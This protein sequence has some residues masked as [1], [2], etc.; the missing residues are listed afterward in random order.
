MRQL[1]NGKLTECIDNDAFYK[2]NNND[3]N[4]IGDL[5][6]TFSCSIINNNINN[7]LNNS[8]LLIVSIKVK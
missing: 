1:T 5:D 8:D 7:N 3:F 2:T 4:L 6:T